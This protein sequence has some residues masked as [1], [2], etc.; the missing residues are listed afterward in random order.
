MFTL[1]LTEIIVIVIVI[2]I[3]IKPEDLPRFLKKTSRFYGEI[4]K[5]YNEV[6][7]IKED[8]I[9][10]AETNDEINN[11]KTEKILKTPIKE[12]KKII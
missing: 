5:S 9:K 4:K 11:I 12:P 1:G 10:I 8:F 3:I 2:I 7:K 6:T